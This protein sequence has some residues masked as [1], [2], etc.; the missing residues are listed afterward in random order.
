M[1]QLSII[2]TFACIYSETSFNKT[3]I[4]LSDEGIEVSYILQ[5][6]RDLIVMLNNNTNNNTNNVEN[7]ETVESSLI[8][9]NKERISG[10]IIKVSRGRLLEIKK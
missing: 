5:I 10:L 6:I 9:R 8:N 1:Q 3:N 7:D 2:I 4:K